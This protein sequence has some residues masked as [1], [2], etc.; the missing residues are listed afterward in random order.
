[1]SLKIELL[2]L[3]GNDLL[4]IIHDYVGWSLTG[5]RKQKNMCNFWSKKWSR[6]LKKFEWWLLTRELL[7][8]YLTEKQ[9]D[10]LRS[11]RLQE[12]VTT[13]ELTVL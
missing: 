10:C 12:V 13:R 7:K 6:S 3:L 11:G 1:M 4:T 8:Q 9:N 2:S 5:N